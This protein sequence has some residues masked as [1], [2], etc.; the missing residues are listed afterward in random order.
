MNTGHRPLS[1]AFSAEAYM[2]VEIFVDTKL[3]ITSTSA[4][5]SSAGEAQITSCFQQVGGGWCL[6]AAQVCL[7]VCTMLSIDAIQVAAVSLLESL[8]MLL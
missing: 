2:G 7:E 5:M 6:Y 3:N 1:C 4:V 8:L